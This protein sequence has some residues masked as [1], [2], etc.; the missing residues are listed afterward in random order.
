[1][2]MRM[3]KK[4]RHDEGEVLDWWERAGRLR[5]L[6]VEVASS[7]RR[8]LR[9]LDGVLRMFVGEWYVKEVF[10]RNLKAVAL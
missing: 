2:L 3:M 10:S 5:S 9:N 4:S 8:E 6:G 1:M 7:Q